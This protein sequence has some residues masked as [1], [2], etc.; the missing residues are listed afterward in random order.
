MLIEE[1]RAE[2]FAAQLLEPLLFL[3][4]KGNRFY[5]KRSAER[6]QFLGHPSHLGIVAAQE[7]LRV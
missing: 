5:Q 7:C 3:V 6:F 1:P 4:E 2:H